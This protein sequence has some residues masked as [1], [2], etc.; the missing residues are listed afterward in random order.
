MKPRKSCEDNYLAFFSLM[1][2]FD[3][4]FTIVLLSKFLQKHRFLLTTGELRSISILFDERGNI[5]IR[6]YGKA[7]MFQAT[8]ASA[9]G[10]KNCFSRYPTPDLKA[11]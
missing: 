5:V 6:E 8:F 3:D 9:F 10:R 11:L 1:S 4:C 7:E 2:D